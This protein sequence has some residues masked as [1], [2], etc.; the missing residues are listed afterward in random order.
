MIGVK[1]TRYW[2][3]PIPIGT[4][5]RVCIFKGSNVLQTTY[6][7]DLCYLTSPSDNISHHYTGLTP[8]SL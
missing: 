2:C 3:T 6:R 5:S 8:E 1:F 4:T 7:D